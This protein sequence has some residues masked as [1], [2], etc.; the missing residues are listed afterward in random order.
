MVRIA[1]VLLLFSLPVFVVSALAEQPPDFKEAYQ[2]YSELVEQGK[3]SEAIPYAKKALDIAL[4]SDA[5]DDEARGKLAF[6]L[7]YVNYQ[8]R[9]L[10][11]AAAAFS[12]AIEKLEKTTKPDHL[13]IGEAHLYRGLCYR[14]LYKNYD[15]EKDLSRAVE[16][17]TGDSPGVRI[18]RADALES[19]AWIQIRRNRPHHARKHADQAH[20]I[21]SEL[22]PKRHPRVLRAQVLLA[23]IEYVGGKHSKAR[24][25]LAGAVSEAEKIQ[26]TPDGAPGS[27]ATGKLKELAWFHFEVAEFYALMKREKD[28]EYHR[29]LAR[30]LNKGLYPAVFKV[31][32]IDRSPPRFPSRAARHRKIGWVLLEYTV[33]SDGSTADI[34]V[35][36][37]APEGYFEN[38]SK[39]AVSRWKYEPPM[40]DGKPTDVKGV[41]TMIQFRFEY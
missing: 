17:L 35:I 25:I 23:A 24:D 33:R 18:I 21:Y 28:S 3:E 14:N 4:K 29:T 5:F 39:D 40:E 1:L 30:Q 20:K 19:L 9:R 15:A 7:G 8:D 13:L 12:I 22:L 36:E 34:Q 16:M 10:T 37:A 41:R 11:D 6:N 27:A 38:V 26:S 2:T 31:K 32:P